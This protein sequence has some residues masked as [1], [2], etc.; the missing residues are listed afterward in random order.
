MPLAWVL[1]PFT[2]V[3]SAGSVAFADVRPPLFI[4]DY[5]Y[6]CRLTTQKLYLLELLL[7]MPLYKKL[8]FTLTRCRH[9]AAIC[10]KLN[11]LVYL[12]VCQLPL[13]Q[14]VIINLHLNSLILSVAKQET[15]FCL[16]LQYIL[17]PCWFRQ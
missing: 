7:T 9:S 17:M 11:L 8:K 6:V 12:L 1:P 5:L 15:L 2:S 14:R 16:F 10:S 4:I 3:W 13:M